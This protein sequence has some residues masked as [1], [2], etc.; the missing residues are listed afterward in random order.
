MGKSSSIR[1]LFQVHFPSSRSKSSSL[2]LMLSTCPPLS[3]PESPTAI[4]NLAVSQMSEEVRGKTES[5]R[6][7]TS[8][9]E[10]SRNIELRLPVTPERTLEVEHRGNRGGGE[11]ALTHDLDGRR[12]RPCRRSTDA[13]RCERNVQELESRLSQ[14]S[15]SYSFQTSIISGETCSCKFI[16]S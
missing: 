15:T 8:V 4:Q 6:K 13:A 10:T 3:S 7:S 14:C 16:G 9:H 2:L 1:A 5:S 11:L 12:R